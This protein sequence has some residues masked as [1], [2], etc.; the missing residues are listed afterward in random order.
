MLVNFFT[1]KHT[2]ASCAVDELYKKFGPNTPQYLPLEGGSGLNYLFCVNSDIDTLVKIVDENGYKVNGTCMP[3]TQL[4]VDDAMYNSKHMASISYG[5]G[6]SYVL[7]LDESKR[8]T[9][10]I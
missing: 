3:F 2:P 10:N 9:A 1:V 6:A 4:M 8:F 7:C 5:K